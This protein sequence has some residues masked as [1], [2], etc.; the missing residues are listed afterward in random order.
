MTIGP[1]RYGM[2]LGAVS[3]PPPGAGPRYRSRTCCW[4][5]APHDTTARIPLIPTVPSPINSLDII[6]CANRSEDAATSEQTQTVRDHVAYPGGCLLNKRCALVYSRLVNVEPKDEFATLDRLPRFRF[7]GNRTERRGSDKFRELTERLRRNANV[8]P[9]PPPRRHTRTTPPPPEV[10][11]APPP[12]NTLRPLPL[13][14]ASFSQVDYCPDDNKYVR[15]HNGQEVSCP[16]NNTLPRPKN[17]QKPKQQ[18]GFPS[19]TSVTQ[20]T[21]ET[22]KDIPEVQVTSSENSE[23]TLVRPQNTASGSNLDR[24]RDRSR[25]RKGIYLPQWPTELNDGNI[26]PKYEEES[27]KDLQEPD[28]QSQ[29]EEP[30]TPDDSSAS[31]EWPGTTISNNNHN[32]C[33][34]C[35][36]K[37]SISRSSSILRSD[38]LSE[39]EPDGV[40]HKLEQLSLVP[41]DI[42]DCESR[43]SANNDPFLSPSIPR[44]YSKRP[45]RGPYGQMLEAEM[46][47]PE[48]RKNLNNDL[49]FLED[50]SSQPGSKPKHCRSRGPCNSSIDETYLKEA[51]IVPVT[52]RKVSADNLMLVEPVVKQT[53]VPNHQRTTSSPSKLEGVTANSKQEVSK[54]FLEQL[55][56]AGSDQLDSKELGQQIQKVSFSYII[57]GLFI[58]HP[59]GR[60]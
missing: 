44:R 3:P 38:S 9:V 23:K 55:R 18:D 49:K 46:K 13:R 28:Q 2:R 7:G 11:V 43:L 36:P 21:G 24:R 22:S 58:A 20:S 5:A 8:T 10:V 19:T 57:N 29:L 56:K 50:L 48:T 35:T 25:R 33:N 27:V 32:T 4:P 14:S 41:S 54:E 47:K 6:S 39:G 53:L 37:V 45:L 26:L 15:R 60:D 30:L 40:E 51:K 12:V 17:L 52:K 31:L 34:R 42:S 16:S 1:V 59:I